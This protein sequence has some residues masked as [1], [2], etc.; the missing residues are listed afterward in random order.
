M[1]PKPKAILSSVVGLAFRCGKG[2][3]AEIREGLQMT[4]SAARLQ[5][6]FFP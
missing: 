5:Q 6:I 3:V 2:H 4:G 1:E